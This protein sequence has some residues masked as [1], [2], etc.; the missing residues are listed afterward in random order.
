MQHAPLNGMIV[1]QMLQMQNDLKQDSGANQ[2]TRGETTAGVVSAKAINS[3]QEAGG[4][5]TGMHTDT[6]NDGY[7]RIVEQVLWLMAEFYDG[8]R[9]LFITGQDGKTREVSL[10]PRKYFR[11]K[12]KGELAPPPYMVRIEINRR[13]PVQ[14]EAQNNMFMQAYTMAA[15]A[16]QYFPLSALFRLMNF[17]GKERLMPVV[18][19]AEEKQQAMQQLQQQN[20]QLVEQLAKMQ[21][22]ND[23]LRVTGTQMTNAL[24]S[25]G[26]TSG[27]GAAIQPGGKVAQ[28][29]GG[30][31]TQAALVN[32]ARE[33]MAGKPAM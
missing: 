27:G 23:N 20:Q 32:R 12:K 25:I 14:V 4:K 29:G 13:D 22:E 6:L 10:D 26:A 18:L 21:K 9:M 24:A 7:K 31:G 11:L 30:P 8:E 1:Q 3:L 17:T 19:E 2:F 15:Q 28:A 5:I 16:E 33:T